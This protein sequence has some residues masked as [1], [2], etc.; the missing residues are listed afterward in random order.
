MW[1]LLLNDMSMQN[2]WTVLTFMLS[3]GNCWFHL[4]WSCTRMGMQHA[5]TRVMKVILT[6]LGLMVF[7]AVPT[8]LIWWIVASSP[9]ASWMVFVLGHI[10]NIIWG[11]IRGHKNNAATRPSRVWKLF[12][13]SCKVMQPMLLWAAVPLFLGYVNSCLTPDGNKLRLINALGL[14]EHFVNLLTDSKL[15]PD[16]GVMQELQLHVSQTEDCNPFKEDFFY[17]YVPETVGRSLNLYTHNDAVN[18]SQV[19]KYQLK[20]WLHKQVAQ[21]QFLNN[22]QLQTVS[23][24]ARVDDLDCLSTQTVKN[25]V[26]TLTNREGVDPDDE[27]YVVSFNSETVQENKGHYCL[28]KQPQHSLADLPSQGAEVAKWMHDITESTTHSAS[29]SIDAAPEYEVYSVLA[30]LLQTLVF[31]PLQWVYHKIKMLRKPL[32]AEAVER[33]V[34]VEVDVETFV[35]NLDCKGLSQKVVDSAQLKDLHV[36]LSMCYQFTDLYV[37]LYWNAIEKCNVNPVVLSKKQYRARIGTNVH[38]YFWNLALKDNGHL[39]ENLMRWYPLVHTEVRWTPTAQRIFK[40]VSDAMDKVF[41]EPKDLSTVFE[42]GCEPIQTIILWGCLLSMV[43]NHLVNSANKRL[44]EQCDENIRD[45]ML[46]V[47]SQCLV[48]N[49]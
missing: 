12:Q 43:N 40:E 2:V 13:A 29:E 8:G 48:A 21:P 37:R 15:Y 36:A 47:M 27:L 49:A 19:Q 25:L 10:V 3:L 22:T 30:Q 26:D 44:L 41:D 32:Q 42:N 46:R 33:Q 14:S 39:V 5:N 28:V 18:C 11:L 7:V 38:L 45:L 31:A 35:K 20:E 34:D 24:N 23:R 1:H 6:M 16:D 9:I 17:H 4:V